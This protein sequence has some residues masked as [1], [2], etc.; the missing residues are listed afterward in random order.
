MER[1]PG[2]GESF[3]SVLLIPPD[4]RRHLFLSCAHSSVTSAEL[5][6]RFQFKIVVTKGITVSISK[7]QAPSLVPF[8]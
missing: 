8:G 3:P 2:G 4:K 7:G 6:T 5:Q 1:W